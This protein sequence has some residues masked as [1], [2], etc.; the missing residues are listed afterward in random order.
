MSEELGYREWQSIT[1]EYNNSTADGIR[2]CLSLAEDIKVICS[3]HMC[4]DVYYVLCVQESESYG[5]GDKI[6]CFEKIKEQIVTMVNMEREIND[7][8]SATQHVDS[9]ATDVQASEVLHIG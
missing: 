6:L 9:I 1:T 3:T 2:L 4:I 8:V 5:D 7:I